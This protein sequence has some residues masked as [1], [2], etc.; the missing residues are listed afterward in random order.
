V[1]RGGEVERRGGESGLVLC[2]IQQPRTSGSTSFLF[3]FFVVFAQGTTSTEAAVLFLSTPLF[4]LKSGIL[5]LSL[6]LCF[7]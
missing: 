2:I 5:S 4:L 3:Y 6:L 1:T 7:F